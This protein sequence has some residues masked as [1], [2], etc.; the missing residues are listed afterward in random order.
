MPPGSEFAK[1]LVWNASV[2]HYP[3][4]VRAL[5]PRPAVRDREKTKHSVCVSIENTSNIR[6]YVSAGADLEDLGEKGR[7][8]P[9]SAPADTCQPQHVR[10]YA[11]PARWGRDPRDEQSYCRQVVICTTYC[12]RFMYFVPGTCFHLVSPTPAHACVRTAV[13]RRAMYTPM[14]LAALLAE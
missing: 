13:C 7:A 10:M 8:T 2:L 5:R 14:C 6:K 9:R 12:S 4:S 11:S 3:R 1:F